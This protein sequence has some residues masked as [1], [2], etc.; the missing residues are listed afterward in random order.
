MVWRRVRCLLPAS[1]SVLLLLH[2]VGSCLSIRGRRTSILRLFI[3]FEQE[4]PHFQS[5]LGPWNYVAGPV[6]T[7]SWS[8]LPLLQLRW[9][10]GEDWGR[11]FW[12]V[13]DTSWLGQDRVGSTS[14]DC[15]LGK[16]LLGSSQE[17][18]VAFLPLFS[19]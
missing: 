14:R 10:T 19:I 16:A 12:M 13:G 7:P 5:T 8:P 17:L 18:S 1:A 15:E 6:P 2:V 9:M 11:Y 3:S 4:D